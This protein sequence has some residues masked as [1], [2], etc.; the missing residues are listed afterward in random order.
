MA[1]K[2]YVYANLNCVEICL[3]VYIVMGRHLKSEE[4]SDIRRESSIVDIC[5]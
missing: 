5:L 1:I 4:M 2:F 3:E